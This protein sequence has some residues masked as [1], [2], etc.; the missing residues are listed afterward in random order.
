MGVS[1][2]RWISYVSPTSTH[3]LTF[4][5]VEERVS[6]FT[7]AS[8]LSLTILC[9]QHPL[10]S[11]L[12]LKTTHWDDCYYSSNS[13]Y[14]SNKSRLLT[15]GDGLQIFSLRLLCIVLIPISEHLLF[16][17]DW[18][19]VQNPTSAGLLLE[20]CAMSYTISLWLS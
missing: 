8:M 15:W 17:W 18:S 9:I 3:H 16:I 12:I 1:P 19:S 11:H 13:T 10:V 7:V 20:S 4:F 2:F 5:E 14:L 6:K